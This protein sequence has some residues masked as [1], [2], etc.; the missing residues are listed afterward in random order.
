[1]G[2]CIYFLT[3]VFVSSV[4]GKKVPPPVSPKPSPPPTLPKPIKM[5]PTHILTPP[6]ELNTHPHHPTVLPEQVE[7][8][9]LG[10]STPKPAESHTLSPRPLTSPAQSPQTP[11]TPSTPG[12]G[13]A[14][15]K[16]PRSSMAGLSVDI[17]SPFEA[18][19]RDVEKHIE[20]D[21]QKRQRKDTAAV[22]GQDTRAST[23]VTRVAEGSGQVLMRRRKVGVARQ[24]QI[25][26]EV[27]STGEDGA[28][29][30][31]E[32]PQR[33]PNAR[34]SDVSRIHGGEEINQLR[35]D[36]T[37]ASLA[38]ALEVVEERIM[39]EDKYFFHFKSSIHIC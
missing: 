25:E 22:R 6:S 38:A 4:D 31:E 37:S 7:H 1:M 2:I 24:M 32:I 34:G 30:A 39:T 17:P 14:P 13:S 26:G 27:E 16:P 29:K 5:K 36:E 12:C 35:L 19:P 23:E 18:E 28:V 11:Q 8:P 9:V 33:A 10:L 3:D 21:E 15:V 20:D